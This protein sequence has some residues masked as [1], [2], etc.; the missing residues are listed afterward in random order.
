MIL[1]TLSYEFIWIVL[2]K[3]SLGKFLKCPKLMWWKLGERSF[4]LAW[5]HQNFE[6]LAAFC[7]PSCEQSCDLPYSRR[8]A[9]WA[10]FV[11]NAVLGCYGMVFFVPVFAGLLGKDLLQTVLASDLS[12][13]WYPCK[14][15]RWSHPCLQLSGKLDLYSKITYAWNYLWSIYSCSYVVVIYDHLCIFSIY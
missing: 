3:P 11:S 13:T 12:R 5:M 4:P 15:L 7:I 1:L 6:F 14:E 9:A 2:K 8:E 10:T